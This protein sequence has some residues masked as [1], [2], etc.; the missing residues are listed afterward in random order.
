[1]EARIRGKG[2]DIVPTRNTHNRRALLYQNKIRTVLKHL[3]CHPE[4]IE[5]STE[6]LAMRKTEAWVNF[7][8]EFEKCHISY[9]KLENYADNMQAIA[10]LL[11]QE[12]KEINESKDTKENFFER[13]EEQGDVI[14]ERIEA[15]ETLGVAVDCMDWKVIDKAYKDLSRTAHPDMGGSVEEFKKINL[16]HKTLKKELA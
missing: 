10:K 4:D 7:Y 9:N 6:K 14:K 1:M 2:V 13:Y 8:S 3:G 16:A 5:F 11:E 15:R 12:E